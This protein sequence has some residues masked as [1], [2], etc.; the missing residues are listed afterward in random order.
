M[1][2]PANVTQYLFEDLDRDNPGR[3]KAGKSA[4]ADTQPFRLANS[5]KFF[6]HWSRPVV[7]EGLTGGPL[8]CQAPGREQPANDINRNREQASR[9]IES[10]EQV[11]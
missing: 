11:L 1:T 5:S 6:Q 2:M 9:K 8:A 3:L 10:A 7:Q 4:R